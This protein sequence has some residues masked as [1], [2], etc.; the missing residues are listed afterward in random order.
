MKLKLVF[1]LGTGKVDKSKPIEDI[2]FEPSH[3]GELVSHITSHFGKH[4]LGAF[5]DIIFL[6]LHNHKAFKQLMDVISQQITQPNDEVEKRGKLLSELCGAKYFR[7][8]LTIIESIHV[9]TANDEKLIDMLY[10]VVLY[11]L[12]N[13][14][15][16]TD[17]VLHC[18][19][20]Q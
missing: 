6:I 11:M 10:L 5:A 9:L 13:C 16:E 17:H 12:E 4:K 8:N 1:S 14:H 7:I 20:R 19:Y 18:I 15:D 2:D 3:A